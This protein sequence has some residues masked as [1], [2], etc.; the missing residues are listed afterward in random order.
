MKIAVTSH[1]V[2]RYLERVTGAEGFHRES[3]RDQIRVIVEQGFEFGLVR[4][5]PLV[6]NRRMIPFISGKNILFLSIGPN[7]TDFEADLAVIGVLF[8]KEVSGGKVSMGVQ[9]GDLYP[10]L[11]NGYE[12]RTNP[13]FLIFVGPVQETVDRYYA[14]SD[15]EVRDILKHREPKC[16]ETTIYQLVE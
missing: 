15:D 12:A 5:H 3:V 4:D 6:P 8:E 16:D 7:T 11:R 10:K 13:R 9:L 14:N 2:D 1:A